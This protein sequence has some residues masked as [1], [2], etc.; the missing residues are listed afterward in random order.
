[1]CE[2]EC[3]CVSTLVGLSSPANERERADK[4]ILCCNAMVPHTRN[5]IHS[6]RLYMDVR[7]S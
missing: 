6:N 5:V 7:I 2:N 4:Y 1:M 3:V